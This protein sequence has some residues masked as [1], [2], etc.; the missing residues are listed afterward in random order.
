M[1]YIRLTKTDG[2][3]QQDIFVRRDSVFW[4]QG[5]SEAAMPAP[6]DAET[7]GGGAILHFAGGPGHTVTVAESV[8]N[9]VQ[10]LEGDL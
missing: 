6:D 1:H 7:T 9:V 5:T 8:A 10:M 4:V 2:A 3:R